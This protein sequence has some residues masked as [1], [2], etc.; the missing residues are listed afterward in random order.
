MAE[1]REEKGM[2]STAGST[3]EPEPEPSA[4]Y[5]RLAAKSDI[6]SNGIIHLVSKTHDISLVDEHISSIKH[7]AAD[8]DEA[9]KAVWPRRQDIRYTQVHVLLIR[10]EDDDLGVITEVQELKHVFQHI[11]NYSVETYDISSVMPQRTL[12]QRIQE[13]LK[14]DEKNGDETLL[15]V[16]YAGHARRVPDSNEPP[17]WFA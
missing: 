17:L 12:N 15:I 3:V 9:V 10:W 4:E 6:Y 5:T 14:Y 13:F 16:Y 1:A 2:G 7:L 11:Y 8:L